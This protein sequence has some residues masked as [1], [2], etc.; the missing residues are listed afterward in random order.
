[1]P[2]ELVI[3]ITPGADG[4][5]A[6][7]ALLRARDWISLPASDLRIVPARGDVHFDRETG[8]FKIEITLAAL[9]T[10]PPPD[11]PLIVLP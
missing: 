3:E 2:S 7:R 9:R 6:G 1:M 10:K 8:T 4:S 11:P 5:D